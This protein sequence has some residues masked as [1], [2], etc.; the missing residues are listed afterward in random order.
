MSKQ[1]LTI[2]TL[3]QAHPTDIFS[4]APIP[5][6]VVSA[7]GSSN[8]QIHSTTSAEF[9][10]LQT[11]SNA[12]KLGCH[13]VTSS[14]DGR[15]VASAGFGGEVKIWSYTGEDEKEGQW[16]ELGKLP[17]EGKVGEVWAI[18]LG[19]DGR[20]LA[21][22]SYDGRICVWDLAPGPGNWVKA[23]EYETKGSF[24]VS[25]AMVSSILPF[26]LPLHGQSVITREK[27]KLSVWRR[28][29]N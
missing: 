2:H 15:V 9:P 16:E 12:H 3:D 13:H 28:A 10:H 8:I 1:Y 19:G 4:L 22:S 25:V 14:A 21:T 5:N 23:R 6:A 11:L 26:L 27:E 29:D 7:S 18:N 20:Y 24:G 17:V